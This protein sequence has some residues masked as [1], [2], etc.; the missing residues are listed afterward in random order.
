M[1]FFSYQKIKKII[2]YKKY[3]KYKNKFNQTN[4]LYCKRI[5]K[6]SYI[7]CYII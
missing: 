2:K 3:K 7:I 6:Q 1:T 5:Q 4:K